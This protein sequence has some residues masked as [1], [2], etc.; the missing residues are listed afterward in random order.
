MNIVLMA[1]AGS[2]C[3]AVAYVLLQAI[4]ARKTNWKKDWEGDYCSTSDTGLDWTVWVRG[5]YIHMVSY[6]K[7][8]VEGFY[9]FTTNGKTGNKV[10]AE[11]LYPKRAEV[12]VTFSSNTLT[13]E[14]EEHLYTK[15][16]TATR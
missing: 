7:E 4:I 12:F 3:L 14:I 9:A 13:I 11:V 6:N 2:L 1:F 8:G 5:E 15:T 16:V 10:R